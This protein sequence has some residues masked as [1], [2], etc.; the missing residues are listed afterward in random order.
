M[1]LASLGIPLRVYQQLVGRQP[2]AG[3]QAVPEG[4]VQYCRTF[5]QFEKRPR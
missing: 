2:L 5:L 3:V 1:H 4:D